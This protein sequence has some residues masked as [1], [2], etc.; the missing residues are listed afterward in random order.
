MKLTF[1]I[2]SGLIATSFSAVSSK[3]REV[4]SVGGVQD[5]VDRGLSP[6]NFHR[7]I[8]F[9]SISAIK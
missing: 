8:W 3:Y 4:L 2:Y 5:V 1:A 7:K 9:A 6:R